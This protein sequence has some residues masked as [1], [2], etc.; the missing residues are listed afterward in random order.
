MRPYVRRT[1]LL[2]K[3]LPEQ[4]RVGLESGVFTHLLNTV[5][6]LAGDA[7]APESV[8]RLV[9]FLEREHA[10]YSRFAR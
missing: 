2:S 10:A 7:L 5:S 6:T 4:Y 9:A 8:T 3:T 1:S